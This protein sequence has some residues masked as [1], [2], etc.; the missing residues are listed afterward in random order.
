MTFQELIQEARQLGWQDQLHLAARLLHW[1]EAKMA[2]QSIEHQPNI[3]NQTAATEN[4]LNLQSELPFYTT[5]GDFE[6]T[7]VAVAE[8]QSRY[9]GRTFSDS[10]DLIREDRDR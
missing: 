9:A 2:A 3:I 6:Q 1:A 7:Q 4:P 10:T 8:A 5:G